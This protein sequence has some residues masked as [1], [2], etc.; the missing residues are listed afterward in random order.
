MNRPMSKPTPALLRNVRALLRPRRERS[1]EPR[2]GVQRAAVRRGR[3]D[4]AR[5]RGRADVLR[6]RERRAL[7]RG[8]RRARGRTIGPGASF[9][10]IALI[11]RRPRTATVVAAS[12]VRAFGLP[13]F[14]FRPFVEA[15]PEVAW[16]L[17]ESMA[18]RLAVAEARVASARGASW[19]RQAS[20]LRRPVA[21][22]RE[23]LRGPPPHRS[24]S[25]DRLTVS[26]P[27]TGSS[28]TTPEDDAANAGRSAAR[29]DDSRE[30]CPRQSCGRPDPRR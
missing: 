12:D 2:R 27:S 23:V 7:R 1:R 4:R 3:Q 30:P 18:D 15:R 5:G 11:D 21:S 13:V 10:E 20:P 14:V 17:L 26:A 19:A 9:G 16:K 28:D 22:C 6:R 8:S 24:R 25:P 29:R